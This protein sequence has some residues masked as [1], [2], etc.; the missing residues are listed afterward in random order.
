[1]SATIRPA[2]V[3]VMMV[4]KGQGRRPSIVTSEVDDSRNSSHGDV[5]V[6]VQVFP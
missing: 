6:A 3:S 2:I 5:L 4:P 1:M